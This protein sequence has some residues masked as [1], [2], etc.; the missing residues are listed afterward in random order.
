MAKRYEQMLPLVEKVRPRRIV[1]VGVHRALR[2]VALCAEALVHTGE[3]EYVGYDVFE[4]LGEQFQEDALNGKGMV[5]EKAARERLANL[6]NRM[7]GRFEFSFIV[8]DTRETLHGQSVKADFAF[9]DGDHR[10]DAIEGDYAALSG[11]RVVVFDDYYR[12][13]EDGSIP[14]LSIYGANAVVDRLAAEGKRT[15]ILPK[16]DLCK[17]GGVSHLAVVYR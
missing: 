17:H 1:E 4:T 13:G 15:E 6:Q 5:T 8:G 11:C 16:G 2:A 12:P 3:V 14:D 7:R 10:V 9:I